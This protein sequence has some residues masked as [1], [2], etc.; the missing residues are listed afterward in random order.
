MLGITHSQLGKRPM[1]HRTLCL[2]VGLTFATLFMGCGGSTSE[3][4]NDVRDEN[5]ALRQE[6]ASLK[7]QLG[8][9]NAANSPT[10]SSPSSSPLSVPTKVADDSYSDPSMDPMLQ[11]RRKH[12]ALDPSLLNNRFDDNPST[13]GTQANKSSQQSTQA[14]S[15]SRERS[16]LEQ[17]GFKREE[18]LMCQRR[19]SQVENRSFSDANGF[20]FCQ[21]CGECAVV[22]RKVKMGL[23]VDPQVQA[24]ATR[25]IEANVSRNPL[26]ALP[27]MMGLATW[28]DEQAWNETWKNFSVL[29][30]GPQGRPQ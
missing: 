29:T 19:R 5:A 20:G 23:P 17:L 8:G 10:T 24:L 4:V 18:C 7:K 14:A 11:Y 15:T 6:I 25:H 22:M 26:L 16:P 27:M 13:P 2:L 9:G 3:N 12:F 21:T 28:G 30:A 1:P